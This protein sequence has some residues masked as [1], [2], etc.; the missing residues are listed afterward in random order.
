VTGVSLVRPARVTAAEEIARGVRRLRLAA[1]D[2]GPLPAWTAGAHLDLILPSGLV[3][4]Y[5]LCGDP[6]DLQEYEIA[7]RWQLLYGGRS[8][9]TMAYLD[10]LARWADQVQ[11]RPQD[12]FGLLDL[13]RALVPRPDTL[14]YCCGPEPLL[15]AV[16]ERCRDWS[17]DSLVV[18]RFTAAEAAPELSGDEAT[19]E[20][21]LGEDGPVVEVPADRS[22][23]AVL[24]DIDADV[25]YSCEEG[26]CGSCETQVISGRPDHRDS[27]LSEENRESGC[28]LICVSRSLDRRLVL[29]IEPP[30]HLAAQ[31]VSRRN[32]A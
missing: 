25:L 20:V 21:Q 2:G 17:R 29:D 22:I 18:E 1:L 16:E 9:D 24:Q 7:V 32:S 23:L 14:V 11:I 8:R 3:R 4:Q 30:A 19:F 6:D 28:M 13:D 27:L 12:E 5:S 15:Q 26:T 31:Q 10:R